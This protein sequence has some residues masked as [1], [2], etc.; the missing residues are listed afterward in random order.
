MIGTRHARL[1]E[2]VGWDLR[3]L[4]SLGG[5]EVQT[6]HETRQGLN[7]ARLRGICSGDGDWIAFID[8]DCVLAADGIEQASNFAQ[9]H[10]DAVAFGGRIQRRWMDPPP[11][12]ADGYGYAFAETDLGETPYRRD[13]L[14][15]AGMT[16][17]P[18]AVCAGRR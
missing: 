12:W 8:D 2:I 11:P 9:E 4:P 16:F 13:W 6:V 7:P 14:A 1:T 5:S 10:P 15:G 17:A 3:R 18:A